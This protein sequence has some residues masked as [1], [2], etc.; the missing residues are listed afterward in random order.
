MTDRLP[1]MSRQGA[2]LAIIMAGVIYALITVGADSDINPYAA[3]YQSRIGLYA[4]KR[5]SL[6]KRRQMSERMFARHVANYEI[7]QYI[8]PRLRPTDTL[9]LPPMS[10]GNR[11]MR[12]KAYWTDPRFFTWMVGFHNVIPWNDTARRSQAN[13]F[14]VLEPTMIWIARRGSRNVNIDS[15]LTE[16][17]RAQ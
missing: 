10:Y 11:Y 16:Y 8:A 2:I 7:P 17:G 13:A 15:L 5:D 12:D 1:L 6:N 3:S 4:A 9:L 14:I